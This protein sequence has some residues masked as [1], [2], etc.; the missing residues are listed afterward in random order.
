VN[1]AAR[2]QGAADKGQILITED[3]YQQ[4]KNSFS[5]KEVGE[6]SLKNKSKPTMAYEVL[7]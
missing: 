2:L 4:V 7:H 1:V 5:C 3:A 6:L